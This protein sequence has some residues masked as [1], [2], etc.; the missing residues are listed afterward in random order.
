MVGS[1]VAGS[2]VVVGV[3]AVA[4]VVARVI[5]PVAV[6]QYRKYSTCIAASGAVAL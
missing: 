3:V 4:V 6:L 5:I 1:I 2:S